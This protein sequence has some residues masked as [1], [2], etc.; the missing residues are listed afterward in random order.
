MFNSN[1]KGELGG[2]CCSELWAEEFSS[3]TRAAKEARNCSADICVDVALR[4]RYLRQN[5]QASVT[6]RSQ[7]SVAFAAIYNISFL[8]LTDLK[9]LS[10]LIRSGWP[11]VILKCDQF[12]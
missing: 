12:T 2:A 5:L 9:H 10:N 6:A 8:L 11:M 7:T 1:I 4:C 3:P